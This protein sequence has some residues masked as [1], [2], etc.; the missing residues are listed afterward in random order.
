M[1]KAKHQLLLVPGFAGKAIVSYQTIESLAVKTPF[2]FTKSPHAAE[3]SIESK[4]GEMS[5]VSRLVVASNVILRLNLPE[6]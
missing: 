6:W 4:K 3:K 1:G 5:R 2:E